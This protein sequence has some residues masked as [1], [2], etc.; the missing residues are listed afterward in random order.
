MV[1]SLVKV[2]MTTY[3]PRL[4]CDAQ[5]MAVNM[6]FPVSVAG[7]VE[8]LIGRALADAGLIEQPNPEGP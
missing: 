8:W 3:R 4:D 5:H 2:R 6:R 7:F 1:C